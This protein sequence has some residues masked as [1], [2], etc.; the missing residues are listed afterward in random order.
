MCYK[1]IR[2]GQHS[3]LIYGLIDLDISRQIIVLL[4]IRP[5]G[6]DD[7]PVCLPQRMDTVP[8]EL[9]VLV[10][11]S[12]GDIYRFIRGFLEGLPDRPDGRSYEMIAV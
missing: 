11:G 12:H 3:H 2:Y 1:G 6:E 5:H 9:P 7:L 4:C 10:D 8:V